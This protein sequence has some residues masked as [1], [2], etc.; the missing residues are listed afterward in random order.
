MPE[1]HISPRGFDLLPFLQYGISGV[2]RIPDEIILKTFG[3]LTPRPLGQI[4]IDTASRCNLKCIMCPLWSEQRK[5]DIHGGL[6]DFELFERIL[7]IMS[8]EAPH[9][10]VSLTPRGELFCH[11]RAMDICR[12]VRAAKYPLCFITNATLLNEEKIRELFEIGTREVRIS[13]DGATRDTYAAIRSRDKLYEVIE[14]ILCFNKYNAAREPHDRITIILNFVLQDTNA[15]EAVAFLRYWAPLVHRVCLLK[16]GTD[17]DSPHSSAVLNKKFPAPAR[18]PCLYPWMHM[19]IDVEGNV[20]PCCAD[21]FVT[22]NMGNLATQSLKSIWL[23][24]KY[25]KLR[26]ALLE[27]DFSEHPTCAKCSN[28][29]ITTRKNAITLDGLECL[30]TEDIYSYSIHNQNPAPLEQFSASAYEQRIQTLM[31][32]EAGMADLFT[33][34]NP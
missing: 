16:W 30:L 31:Q 20:Y 21:G 11:P 14:A 12:A 22:M 25:M 17:K 34:R 5:Q 33:I 4:N 29:N 24:E 27:G 32:D 18:Y 13:I 1:I 3:H 26:K 8:R 9:A 15:A 23:G 6:M 28:W 10:T 7:D 19:H 2:P